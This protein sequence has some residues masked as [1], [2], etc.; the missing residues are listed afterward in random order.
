MP[1]RNHRY[2]FLEFKFWCAATMA[3]APN[4][5]FCCFWRLLYCCSQLLNMSSGMSQ[6]MSQLYA[7]TYKMIEA[8]QTHLSRQFESRKPHSHF[9][10]NWNYFVTQ[11]TSMIFST[12]CKHYTW[13]TD[14]LASLLYSFYYYSTC[15]S[16]NQT[17][18]SII[19]PYIYLLIAFC[20]T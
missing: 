7:P 3:I 8:A 11:T 6:L 10:A 18:Y 16:T 12:N 15:M 19:N 9:S 4:S 13:A 2:I 17:I 5:K 1:Y 20:S 14:K